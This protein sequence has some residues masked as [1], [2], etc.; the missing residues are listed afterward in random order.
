MAAKVR[1]EQQGW[2]F[3]IN[4]IQSFGT[5]FYQNLGLMVV[6]VIFIMEWNKGK[7]L[8]TGDVLSVLSI[9]YQL[10]F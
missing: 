5:S 7:E 2:I 3:K 4:I 10:F 8:K 6:L 9:I 1:K